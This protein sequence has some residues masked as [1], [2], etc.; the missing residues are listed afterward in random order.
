[1]TSY[2]YQIIGKWNELDWRHFGADVYYSL[3]YPATLC[4]Y[5]YFSDHFYIWV[6]LDERLDKGR[7]DK[8]LAE[9]C[10]ATEVP[11]VPPGSPRG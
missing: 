3:G 9:V 7:F 4:K 11:G 6:N 1:M 8:W 5:R 2:C 10:G